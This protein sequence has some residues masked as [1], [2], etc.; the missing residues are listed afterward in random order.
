MARDRDPLAF[1]AEPLPTAAGTADRSALTAR[2]WGTRGSL[3]SPGPATVRYGGNTS[4]LEV[5]ADGRVLIFDAGSGIRGL[6]ERLAAE[7]PTVDAD[8]FLSHFHW[9][10]IQGLPFFRPLYSPDTRLRV[11]GA[12]QGTSNVQSLIA[13]QMGPIYFP[14]PFDAL[15]ARLDFHDLDGTPVILG[16]VEVAAHRARHPM[17]TFGF[18]IRCGGRTIAYFP[19]NELVGGEYDMPP[20]WYESLCSFLNGV[21]VLIH[22]AM[23]THDE[24]KMFAGWGH[25]TFRDAVQLAEDARVRRLLL[26]HHAPERSDSDLE[27]FVGR[28][29][30][31]LSRRNSALHLGIA[32]E[33]ADIVFEEP[34]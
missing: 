25:S 15:S 31:D 21:D 24:Y 13:G 32:V 18:R 10:H 27:T 26:F 17:N 34:L 4:C 6:G 29:Q 28:I 11:H 3:P 1:A 9:D 8:L 22:D 33:G 16:A 20:D 7:Q 5:R 2:C 30:D 23:F 12:P 19:D 14:V